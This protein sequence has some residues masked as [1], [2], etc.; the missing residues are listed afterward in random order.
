MRKPIAIGILVSVILVYALAAAGGKKI[1]E[2]ITCEQ[3]YELIQKHKDDDN[4]VIIDFR[5][6]E[7][8]RNAYL[9]NAV[10]YD[11]FLKGADEWLDKLDRKKTYLLYCTIGHR[12]GIALE[13]MKKMGFENVFHMYEGV[14]VWKKKGYKT[15]SI[16]EEPAEPIK[17]VRDTAKES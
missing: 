10:F 1:K 15:L 7:K 3:A 5:P 13:K 6:I 16:K 12:S 11:I 4:F 8:Y 2:N 9:E 14:R 17:D